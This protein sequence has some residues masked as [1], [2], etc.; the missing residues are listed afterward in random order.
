MDDELALRKQMEAGSRAKTVLETEAFQN[1]SNAVRQ[2]IIDSWETCPI[3][4]RDGAH[5]LKLMLKLHADLIG[6]LKKAVDDGKFAADELKRDKTIT[7]RIAE[8]LRIM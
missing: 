8:R 3:R 1:A 7:Q 4:D 2:A 6:H 5:E